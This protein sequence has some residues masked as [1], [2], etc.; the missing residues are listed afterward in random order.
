MSG[1]C[2]VHRLALVTRLDDGRG[3]QVFELY[4]GW[5][6]Y[7]GVALPYDVAYAVFCVNRVDDQLSEP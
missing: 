5:L 4:P 3:V 1:E 7:S 2:P 6:R